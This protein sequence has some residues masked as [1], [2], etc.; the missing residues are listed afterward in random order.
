LLNVPFLFLVLFLQ[1]YCSKIYTI[2]FY[3][4]LTYTAISL[5][6]NGLW[7]ICELHCIQL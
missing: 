3:L 2:L 1:I 4:L 6:P 5:L 7:C